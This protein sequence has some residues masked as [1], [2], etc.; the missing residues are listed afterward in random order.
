[1]VGHET[2]RTPGLLL[3]ATLCAAAVTGQFV[4][5][6]AMR[7]ALFLTSLDVTALPAMLIAT[8][9]CS[10]LLVALHSRC[11]QRMTP[12]TLIPIS[13]VLSGVL[14]LV[15]WMLRPATP[16]ATAITVFLHISGA[17]PLLTSGFWLIASERFDPR[18]AKRRFGQLAG[19][20]TLG[21]LLSAL[22][23]ERVAALFGTPA[24]LPLLAVLQFASAA[25]V[26]SLAWHERQAGSAAGGSAA[27]APVRSG[28]RVIAE[29]P[30]LRHLAALVLLGTTGA[31]LVDYL[32]KAHAVETFGRG[33]QLLR[34]FAIYYA[35]TSILTFLIQTSSSRVMLERFGL[36]LTTST[37]SFALLLASIGGLLVPG[38]GSLVLARGG[39]S[40]FRSSLFRAGYELFYTPIPAAEKRAA[41]SLIDVAFDRLGDA[42]GGGLVRLTIVLLP[43][44]QAPAI[45]SLA[46]A[47][48]AGAVF[49]ASRLNRGYISTLESSLMHHALGL[50]ISASADRCRLDP[51]ARAEPARARTAGAGGAGRT[52]TAPAPQSAPKLDPEVQDILSLRSRDRERI[53]RGAVAR[54]RP[55]GGARAARD[56]VAR[57]G[58]GSRTR[59]VCAAEGRRR[60][61]RRVRRRADRSQSGL[62]RP[63][64]SRA[65]VLGLRVA[66]RRRTARCSASTTCGSRCGFQCGPSL[67]A[68]VDKNPRSRSTASRFS[69][70]FSREVACRPAGLGRPSAARRLA[71]AQS[72][73]DPFVRDRA[74]E[75]L[76]HVFT[77]LS[78]VL[79]REPL[80][81]A[82]R[83]LQ[84]DD[85]HLQ[86]TAL[87]YLEGVLPAPIR[88]R[89]WPFLERRPS[90]RPARPREEVIAEL[91]RSTPVDPAQ[92][93]GT[94]GAERRR[95][96]GGA[97]CK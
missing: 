23:A 3:T 68:I 7:D 69:R 12:G 9:A 52:R 83:S 8:S 66:A 24:M 86:G 56:P 59:D 45:L 16:T 55:A 93:R 63:A 27:A 14:F 42:V 67:A 76:A 39:E 31:A 26:R 49:A 47:C 1:M 19:A 96:C 62:R 57:L 41:K 28:L 90:R 48:S 58:R 25:L 18:T 20:G 46:F 84:T 43:A 71:D 4:A 33:D 51:H 21:G 79:P 22:V 88:E 36:G 32:F 38:F 97:R 10:M 34:F 40:I 81:L 6:K 61:C 44:L 11:A 85:R 77:L 91:L 65:R 35:G 64:P 2:S 73:L 37:P 17:G 54:A 74:G 15:E 82:F 89:L 80:Q 13:F 29:A 87:E 5:G 60:A 50:D 78:L 70:S 92:P 53:I 30:Y 72:P 94:R 75:S 95:R